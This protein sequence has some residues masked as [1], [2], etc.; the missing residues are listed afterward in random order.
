MTT[1]LPKVS[2][3]SMRSKPRGFAARAGGESPQRLHLFED[4]L[5]LF[6]ELLPVGR[7]A[8]V[9]GGPVEQLH[10]ELRFQT[11]DALGNGGGSLRK[12]A[13]RHGKAGV[14]GDRGEGDNLLDVFH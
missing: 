7:Q 12:L 9:A 1:R 8:Y 13:S 11:A 2:G 4:A 10:A 6:E 3:V 5:A 14:A